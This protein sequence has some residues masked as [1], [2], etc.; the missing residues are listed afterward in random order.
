[1]KIFWEIAKDSGPVNSAVMPTA[2]QATKPGW[3]TSLRTGGQGG[4]MARTKTVS[5][6]MTATGYAYSTIRMDSHWALTEKAYG[7]VMIG[8]AVS[9]AG[10][11]PWGMIQRPIASPATAIMRSSRVNR[12]RFFNG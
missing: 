11:S 6:Q 5:D 10:I 3:R 8:N 9:A 1:M 2:Q 4:V 7:P 12:R